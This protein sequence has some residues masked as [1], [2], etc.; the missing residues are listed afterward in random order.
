MAIA[1]ECRLSSHFRWKRIVDRDLSARDPGRPAPRRIRVE[2]LRRCA[3][4]RSFESPEQLKAQIL[5]DV[6]RAQTYF[7]R[8]PCHN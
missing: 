1:N 4:K 8:V 3:M 6:K 5:R 2:F 7:R